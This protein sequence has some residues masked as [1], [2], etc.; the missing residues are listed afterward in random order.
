[1]V[2]NLCFEHH[3]TLKFGPLITKG[4]I[5]KVN[6]L[7]M[8]F[9]TSFCF[10]PIKR[11]C[12]SGWKFYIIYVSCLSDRLSWFLHCPIAFLVGWKVFLMWSSCG[13]FCGTESYRPAS[14]LLPHFSMSNIFLDLLGPIPSVHR[15]FP[16]CSLSA[17][18]H[19]PTS[20]YLYYI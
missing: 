18:S 6:I 10:V 19:T 8:R 11:K 14:Y 4:V 2:G 5:V 9:I 1:M 15:I 20:S 7:I 17:I 16:Y 13:W 12:P 3:L